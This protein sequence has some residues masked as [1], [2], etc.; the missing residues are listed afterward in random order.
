MSEQRWILVPMRS[1]FPERHNW[2]YEL[3]MQAH[4]EAE[5]KTVK[6]KLDDKQ[7]DTP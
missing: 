2:F 4:K 6:H 5:W 7:E 3:F 1:L